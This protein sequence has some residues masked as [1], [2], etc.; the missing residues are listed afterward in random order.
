VNWSI[1]TNR[2]AMLARKGRTLPLFMA[3]PVA[4]LA[5]WQCAVAFGWWPRTLI[6]S[7]ADVLADFWR[8]LATR[9]L[10]AHARVSLVRLIG[11]FGLGTITA[12]VLGSVIGLSKTAERM[13]APTL[14]GIL[15]I[16]P[17]AW[18][19]LIIIL[20]GIGEG[21]KTALIAIGAFGV[22]YFS[23][24]QAIRGADQKLVE[25]AMMLQKS[26]RDLTFYVLLPG[27]LPGILTGMR[28]ALGLSWILLIAAEMIAA[29]IV[30]G[31]TRLQGLGL[32]WLIYDARNFSRADDM[33]VGM[34]TIGLL[35]KLTD[36]LMG[37]LQGRL[38]EWRE[39]FQGV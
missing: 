27:A 16:P 33:I 32:G 26:R 25:V 8:L 1:P 39:V 6:A 30:S 31:S 5:I 4:L 29:S 14:Q 2:P 18:T 38:L 19:P 15:P 13:L 20:L 12:I 7:P 23:T 21:S 11:G 35:G 17:T 37:R 10:L 3:L 36:M 24:L 34:I 9:E 22:V 28:V